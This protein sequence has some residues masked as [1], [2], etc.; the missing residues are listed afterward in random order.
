MG[1]TTVHQ[2]ALPGCEVTIEQM[3]G[4]PARK[5]CSAAHRA[6][7]RRLRGGLDD[8][9]VDYPAQP[10]RMTVG[11]SV[12]PGP[13]PGH[14]A[15]GQAPSP[16]PRPAPRPAPPPPAPAPAPAQPSWD[17]HPV[18]APA[19]NAGQPE[20]SHDPWTMS[21]A[22]PAQGNPAPQPMPGGPAQLG[23]AYP[24]LSAQGHPE[25]PRR[26]GQ[27]DYG[28]TGSAADL[29]EDMIVRSRVERPTLGWR[30]AVFS[31]SG[32]RI[33]PGVSEAE[34]ER[35]IL[36]RRIRRH[37]PGAH[38]IA[39]SSLK[40][41]VGKTTVSA[42]L[43]LTLAEYRGDRVVALDANPDAG[44]LADRLTGEIGVTVRQMLDNIDSIDSLTAVSH[45]TSLAGRLQVLASEQDPAMSEAFNRGEYEQICAVLA[46]FYNIIITDSGTGLVHSAM[47]GT[48]ALADSLVVVGAPTVDGA[49]R[50]SK[51]L[52]WLVAHG[53]A[54]QVADAVVVLCCDRV[55]PEIDRERVRAHF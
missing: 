22:G 30:G 54:E 6:A 11:A 32:G 9:D 41:G 21:P 26:Q 42:V 36:L 43:G 12:R 8:A 55:S 39:V 5:Y 31:A 29:S 16:A 24:D 4:K 27:P 34:S 48:L 19:A 38:Q 14:L 3:P 23:P 20:A 40:G 15:E 18:E 13:A 53:Y 52:D 33:N 37:L 28:F 46:R 7:G 17:P 45:Y 35:N 25:Q 49:S 10:G 50:A 1:E 47:E 44:T 51:T 2:C